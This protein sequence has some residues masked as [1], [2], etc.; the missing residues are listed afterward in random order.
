MPTNAPAYQLLVEVEGSPLPADVSGLLAG[1]FVD[2]S[3]TVPD[4]FVLHFSD[5][6]GTVVDKGGFRIGATVKVSVQ[7]TNAE[8][9][10][11]LLTGEVTTLETEVDSSGKHLAVRGLDVSHR[12]FRGR[13]AEAYV[14]M[15]PS[16]IVRQVA[17]RAGLQV[18]EL[19]SRGTVLPH[20]SQPALNDWDF[21]QNLARD[22]GAELVVDGGKLS[23]RDPQDAADAPGST[24]AD[25]TPQVIEFGKNLQTV[26]ATVTSAEQVPEVEVRGWDPQVKQVV[27]GTAQARTRSA[28]LDGASPTTFAAT[29]DSPSWV[30]PD[31]RLVA[32]GQA[33]ARADAISERLSGTFAELDG[34]VTGN[35][36]LRAGTAVSLVGLGT[37]FDGKY[38][39]SAAR[40][41]FS[42][43]T[44]YRTSFSVSNQ[45]DR[46]L[47]GLNTGAAGSTSAPLT[48]GVLQAI[49]TDL[50]D[51][52]DLGRVKVTVPVL[53]DRFESGWARVLQ[54]GS[55]ADRGVTWLPE[56]G[57]EVLVAF[58]MG[59]VDEPYVLGG[60]Y[61]GHDKPQHGWSGYVDSSGQVQ[62]RALVGRTGMYVELF[63]SS[64]E[65]RLQLET[66]DGQRVTL[67]QEGDQKIEITASGPVNVTTS[68]DAT[69]TATSGTVKLDA[70]QINLS[71]TNAL[72]LSGSTVKI[73]ANTSAELN[74]ATVKVAGS[75]TAE[76]SS[77]GP[78][79]VRGSMVNIN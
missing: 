57:D 27:V 71:A 48:S 28:T 10:K 60:V 3:S 67:T 6:Y 34:V 72:E 32:A 25:R 31:S 41:E 13:R 43:D 30:E 17:Q 56:V 46:S 5:D 42:P 59:H 74:G 21:L 4:L 14:N 53:S 7:A 24:D 11:E 38:T 70:S 40:H 26:R 45:S 37:Q 64:S 50:N 58:G 36:E 76:L 20:V 65:T 61:N 51:T 49:V 9:P 1:G 12:L 22:I 78:T 62:R 23:L 2:T 16:D 63:E 18:G 35:P 47:Y 29:F 73:T 39:L 15:M 33:Q 54:L 68:K 44:G 19:T 69:V 8:P 75:G 55:G 52:E 77:S 66:N 79:T